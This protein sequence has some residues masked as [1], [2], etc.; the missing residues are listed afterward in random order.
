MLAPSAATSGVPLPEETPVVDEAPVMTLLASEDPACQEG[1]AKTE[2][3]PPCDP[4][5]ALGV[6]YHTDWLEIP[7]V[8][9]PSVDAVPER[10]VHAPPTAR[11]PNVPYDIVAGKLGAT[12]P[13]EF[14][15]SPDEARTVIPLA[16][17]SCSYCIHVES[18]ASVPPHEL[19]IATTCD[20]A[21]LTDVL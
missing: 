19:D 18:L 4:S 13:P 6:L 10:T 2:L 12:F 11:V 5:P 7:V 8:P 9:E 15:L 20:S 1:S 21:L 17:A 3:T 14:P 16:A